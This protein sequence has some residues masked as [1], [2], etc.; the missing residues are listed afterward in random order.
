MPE[1]EQWQ[2]SL[3]EQR[4]AWGIAACCIILVFLASTRPEWFELPAP[5]PQQVVNK[6][7]NR[8]TSHPAPVIHHHQVETP[9]EAPVKTQPSKPKPKK[10]LVV[11]TPK[12]KTPDTT[13]IAS[14]FYVQIGAFHERHR[15][16]GL[17]DQL[18]RKGWKAVISTRKNRLYAVWVG[19][20]Q[21]HASAEKLLLTIQRKL[22]SKGFIV[23][24]KRG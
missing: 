10:R 7:P 24:Q 16:Q 17:T 15:A 3:L 23:H 4:I 2:A 14:G 9:L 5:T 8:K 20:K 6:E 12:T 13:V 11:T 21:T 19:P 22:K 18:K 1:T